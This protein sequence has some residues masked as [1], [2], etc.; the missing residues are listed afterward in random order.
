[1][2]V[3]V[4]LPFRNSLIFNFFDNPE[5]VFFL[6][7]K[8]QRAFTN[9]YSFGIKYLLF[10]SFVISAQ[11]HYDEH[12]RRVSSE[13]GHQTM[14]ID[15][16]YQWGVFYETARRTSLGFTATV[17]RRGFED[18]HTEEG[19]I[20]LS[21]VLNREER[22]GTV[23]FNYELFWNGFF[24]L[25]AGYTEYRFEHEQSF[26]RN[27]HSYQGYAGIRFPLLGAVRGIL[28]LGYKKFIP[29][30]EGRGD[31]SG[32][33]GNTELDIRMGRVGFRLGYSRD[34]VFSYWTSVLFFIE[35]RYFAGISFYLARFLRIDYNLNIGRSIYPEP[36]PVWSD[37]GEYTE[38]LRRDNQLTHS[39][40]LVFR[41][42]KSTGLGLI[43]N[44]AR[45]TS[46]WS[47]WNRKRNFIGAFLTHQ[48]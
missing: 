32:I 13:F 28:S 29:R 22:S 30:L 20:F 36:F 44:S 7:E 5:Y 43:W 6:K 26:W 37:A 35:N 47:G 38:I 15:K 19:E 24:F 17:D 41:V 40:G 8:N 48:F 46:S 11:Y 12:R 4:Y 2:E 3:R 42:F 14:D 10:Y 1:P 34:N 25:T 27:A 31:F 39:A 9:S 21:R 18:V 16:G 23:E 33:V 45:W